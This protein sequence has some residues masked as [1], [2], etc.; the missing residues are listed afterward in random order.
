[1]KNSLISWVVFVILGILLVVKLVNSLTNDLE[2][3]ATAYSWSELLKWPFELLPILWWRNIFVE[4]LL[5]LISIGA[6]LVRSKLGWIIFVSYPYVL[7]IKVILNYSNLGISAPEL[8]RYFFP[9]AI[10][11]LMNTKP[12]FRHFGTTNKEVLKSNMNLKPLLVGT[13][14]NISF[15]LAHWMI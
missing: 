3:F 7:I 12:I 8:G 11:I 2:I 5:I 4:P 13:A 14:L 10:L 9:I 15:F 1:M 6:L